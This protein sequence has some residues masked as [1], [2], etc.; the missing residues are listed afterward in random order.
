[1]TER[2]KLTSLQ[3]EFLSLISQEPGNLI[4]FYAEKKEI[5]KSAALKHY[6]YL[7]DKGYVKGIR[8]KSGGRAT[9]H[10]TTPAERQE[11]A[12]RQRVY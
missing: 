5:T 11:F 12:N 9:L 1:M 6:S 2:T 3:Q 4:E 8:V 10:P 7:K